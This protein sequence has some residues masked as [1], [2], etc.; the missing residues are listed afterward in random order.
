MVTA[1]IFGLFYVLFATA[2]AL[3]ANYGYIGPACA[4]ADGQLYIHGEPQRDLSASE[5]EAFRLYQ[6]DLSIYLE[7]KKKFRIL[8]PPKMPAFCGQL[9]DAAELVLDGCIVR[10]GKVYMNS[11]LVRLLT[12]DEEEKIDNIMNSWSTRMRKMK[13]SP[14]PGLSPL[15]DISMFLDRILKVSP[16]VTKRFD[17]WFEQS[18]LI[19]GKA[20]HPGYDITTNQ[21][22]IETTTTGMPQKT[23]KPSGLVR[24]RS[25]NRWD[26]KFI[27]SAPPISTPIFSR[28]ENIPKSF[29]LTKGAPPISPILPQEQDFPKSEI[30]SPSPERIKSTGQTLLQLLT[31]TLTD[32]ELMRTLRELEQIPAASLARPRISSAVNNYYDKDGSTTQEPEF[33]PNPM[34]QWFAKTTKGPERNPEPTVLPNEICTAHMKPPSAESKRRRT[35][36]F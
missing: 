3:K 17:P 27:R 22:S 16:A 24:R 35:L 26:A 33:L 15:R 13:D 19:S 28:K 25:K 2:I 8:E 31:K 36:P 34:I 12:G 14:G 7:L 11:N 20:A 6:R 30:P 4:V 21:T 9:T 1:K 5:Q 32:P 23:L 10:E 29:E 18:P